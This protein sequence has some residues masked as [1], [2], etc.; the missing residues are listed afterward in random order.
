VAVTLSRTGPTPRQ[1]I[2]AVRSR[3]SGVRAFIRTTNEKRSAGTPGR[4]CLDQALVDLHD[5]HRP[6]VHALNGR[7][8]LFTHASRPQDRGRWTRRRVLDDPADTHTADR[9][10][11]VGG[12]ASTKPGLCRRRCPADCL[13]SRRESGRRTPPNRYLNCRGSKPISMDSARVPRSRYVAL[14]TAGVIDY[15]AR[16]ATRG[17]RAARC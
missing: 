9:R 2:R 13:W 1:T 11:R 12:V 17:R 3:K 7:E 16:R 14:G 6:L 5:A 8:V 15:A 10:H 4:V